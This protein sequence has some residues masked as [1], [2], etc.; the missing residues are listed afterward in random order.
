[1]DLAPVLPYKNAAIAVHA[2]RVM[3]NDLMLGCLL[4]NNSDGLSCAGPVQASPGGLACPAACILETAEFLTNRFSAIQAK[5]MP[6][7]VLNCRHAGFHFLQ[8]GLGHCH[9]I[10]LPVVAVEQFQRQG[11]LSP[12]TANALKDLSQRSDSVP[13]I[14]AV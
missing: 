14:D 7:G 6:S 10:L 4:V 13:G 1:M 9:G 3:M 8:A 12:V 2:A 11:A 5:W